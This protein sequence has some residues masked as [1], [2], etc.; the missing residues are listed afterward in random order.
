AAVVGP[1]HQDA[2][3][4]IGRLVEHELG[5]LVALRIEAHVVE[6]PA[7]VARRA[8]LPQEAGRDDAIGIAVDDVERCGNGSQGGE[9]LHA[10]S[11]YDVRASVMRPMS[12][13]AAAIA[14]P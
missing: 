14:G 7:L 3:S 5:P 2:G 6:Q 13:A 8:R 10:L 12:A 11:S 9:R 4:R 1:G